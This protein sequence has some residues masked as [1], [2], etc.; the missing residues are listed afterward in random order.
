MWAMIRLGW[1]AAN[2]PGELRLLALCD[3]MRSLFCWK[4]GCWKSRMA[5]AERTETQ[6]ADTR[7]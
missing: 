3:L 5:G 4:L 1:E 6:Y 2:H 7:A